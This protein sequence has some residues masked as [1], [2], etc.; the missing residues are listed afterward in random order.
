MKIKG[1]LTVLAFVFIVLK[2]TAQ[3]SDSTSYTLTVA[4][5]I[6]GME[7]QSE[8]E[9]NQI[10]YSLTKSNQGVD[11]A[12]ISNTLITHEE[13]KISGATTL[14]EALRLSPDVF[15]R[16]STNGNYTLH[17]RGTSRPN[18]TLDNRNAIL[19]M[20]NEVPYYNFLEQTVWWE[21]LPIALQDIKRIEVIRF[22]QGAWYGP[23]ATDGII[24]IVTKSDNGIGLRTQANG[25]VG[26]RD[27]QAYQ[28]SI[29]FNQGGRFRAKV[30]G[31]YNQLSR[32]QDEYYIFSQ[33]RYVPSDSLLFY[34]IDAK[35]TNPIAK[36]ALRNSGAYINANYQWNNEIGIQLEGGMQNSESQALH[37]RI[38]QIA[39]TNRL[40]NSNWASL[41]TSWKPITVYASYQRES[42]SYGEYDNRLW[43]NA[44]RYFGRIEYARDW[45]S[46]RFGLGTEALNYQYKENEADSVSLDRDSQLQYSSLL[47]QRYSINLSQQFYLFQNRFNVIMANRGDY[48][49]EAKQLLIN[50]QL[51]ALLKLYPS[52]QISAAI[53][54]GEH[55]PGHPD[56]LSTV[57]PQASVQ[58]QAMISYEAKYRY[59]I[60]KNVNT[61]ITYFNYQP[62]NEIDSTQW[63]NTSY[64]A[65]SGISGKIDWQ[66]SRLLLSGFVTKILSESDNG[67]EWPG[68]L[69][70]LFGGITGRYTAFFGKLQAFA[71]LYYYTQHEYTERPHFFQIPSKFNLSGKLSYQIWEDHSVFFSSQNL[72]DNRN[73]EYAFGDQTRGMYWLGLNLRF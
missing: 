27:N 26:L 7:L 64:Y 28:G 48:Y 59:Q 3:T 9:E 5:D 71:S 40:S 51:S 2:T 61:E 66:V 6:L 43:E 25:R 52:H 65:R 15:V 53:S 73:L 38:Q 68:T 35:N 20:I 33:R 29:S 57:D 37:Q 30:S 60:T 11:E 12:A 69:P 17:L 21:A 49:P 14:L 19:L 34:Q 70:S 18:E 16:Q 39:L 50:H 8:Q 56:Y 63:I 54:L 24:N 58:P 22:S 55:A 72:L 13:I 23:E 67:F 42:F 31:F 47:G 45:K 44:A 62:S 32:F 4:D 10:I 36:G 41:R 46:Y 1:V